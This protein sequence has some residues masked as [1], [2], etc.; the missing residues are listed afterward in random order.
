MSTLDHESSTQGQRKRQKVETENL[1]ITQPLSSKT[2]K[3]IA[4]PGVPKP[5]GMG[6]IS[7]PI[8]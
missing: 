4:N 5:R 2:D 8:I 1:K 7:P 3:P 6:D